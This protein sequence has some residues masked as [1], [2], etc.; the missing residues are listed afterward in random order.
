LRK[1]EQGSNISF[2]V[3]ANFKIRGEEQGRRKEEKHRRL[4][5]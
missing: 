3:G 2:K 5:L 4:Q 1:P